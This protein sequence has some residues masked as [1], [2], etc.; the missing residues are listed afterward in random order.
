MEVLSEKE[1]K[2]YDQ[3]NDYKFVIDC[4]KKE[5]EIEQEWKQKINNMLSDFQKQ[6][7]EFC[8]DCLKQRQQSKEGNEN[9]FIF[10]SYT[11]HFTNSMKFKNIEKAI[12]VL[13]LG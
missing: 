12:L 1:K 10:K 7:D 6:V 8:L 2:Y 3:N 5:K 11:L 9:R 4:E 13:S